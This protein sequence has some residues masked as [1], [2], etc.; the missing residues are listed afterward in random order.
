M[1]LAWMQIHRSRGRGRPEET[2]ELQ[3]ATLKWMEVI[4]CYL[5]EP[6]SGIVAPHNLSSPLQP[7]SV[8][9]SRPA[10]QPQQ[11]NHICHSE[12]LNRSAELAGWRDES[13]VSGAK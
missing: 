12:R 2:L 5:I 4:Y 10:G 8:E 1:R 3:M 9:T 7:P 13:I 11:I 6:P